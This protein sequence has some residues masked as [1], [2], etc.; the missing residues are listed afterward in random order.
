MRLALGLQVAS[1]IRR[2]PWGHTRFAIA[3]MTVRAA[4]ANSAS[5]MHGRAVGRSVAGQAARRFSVCVG[6]GLQE[7]NFFAR[8]CRRRTV[9]TD[10]EQEAEDRCCAKDAAEIAQC[11]S[12][13]LQN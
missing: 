4:Q 12:Q 7:Q 11:R 5:C 3:S 8:L 10:S 13:G 6:L 1:R 2:T 9:S